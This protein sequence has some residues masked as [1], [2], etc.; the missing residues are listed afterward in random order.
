MDEELLET[1]DEE[2]LDE[3]DFVVP[4]FLDNSSEEEIHKKMLDYLPDDIDKSEGGYVYDLTKPTAIEV[5]RMKEFELVEALKLIWPRYAEGAFLDYHAETRGLQR[6]EAINAAG[7]L[8]ITGTLG[9]V[10]PEGSIFTTESINDEPEKEYETLEEVTITVEDG[11]DVKIQCTEAGLNGNSAKNTVN[12]EEEGVDTAIV[13]SPEDNSGKV[14]IVITPANDELNIQELKD[15][16]TNYIMSPDNPENRL[17]PVNAKVEVVTPDNLII[18]INA[19]VELKPG[20]ELTSVT[21]I[22]RKSV[23]NYLKATVNEGKI[24]YTQI[25]NILGDTE[26]V[27]DYSGLVISKD[28]DAEGKTDNIAVDPNVIPEAAVTLSMAESSN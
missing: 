25:S 10:I 22:F 1:I 16:V 23:N 13:F 8:H 27:Y 17:A 4:S 26:G 3:D 11:V 18:N 9:T 24:R 5:S 2:E 21:D 28:G 7:I 19:V 12:L 20:A 14:K 15:K 6:K